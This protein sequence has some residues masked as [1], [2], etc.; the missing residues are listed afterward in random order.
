MKVS[1]TAW[2]EAAHRLKDHRGQCHYLHG[3][4]WQVD[5]EVDCPESKDDMLIDFGVLSNIVKEY[6][7]KLLLAVDDPLS[8]AFRDADGLK[9]IAQVVEFNGPPTAENI[10][11]D[12][13]S[14]VVQTVHRG[15]EDNLVVLT[16][17]KVHETR[18]SCAEC[19][20][21][22]IINTNLGGENGTD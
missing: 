17:V 3:H 13:L 5:I 11:R 14:K 18:N 9:G 15:V 19:A 12:I 10:A 7:H 16:K 4:T 22:S 8:Q 6:D 2:F 20:E 21:K 1:K